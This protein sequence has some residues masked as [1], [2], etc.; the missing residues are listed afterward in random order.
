MAQASNSLIQLVQSLSEAVVYADSSNVDT[1]RKL[2][3]EYAK[4]WHP[5]AEFVVKMTHNLKDDQI[6]PDILGDE[7]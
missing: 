7:W 2:W 6:K 3:N 1:N 5:E 4:E